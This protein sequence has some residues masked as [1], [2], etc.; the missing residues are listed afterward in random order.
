MKCSFL[1]L[2]LLMTRGVVP[3]PHRNEPM[4]IQAQVWRLP[5]K[6]RQKLFRPMNNRGTF[7]PLVFATRLEGVE[8]DLALERMK[9]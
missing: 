2:S 1:A 6:E 3:E 4:V 8:Y 5:E 7:E 9:R